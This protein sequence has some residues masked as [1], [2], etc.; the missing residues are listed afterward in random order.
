MGDWRGRCRLGGGGG[1]IVD[2]KDWRRGP[3]GEGGECR[4]LQCQ[5]TAPGPWRGLDGVA[6]TSHSA[7]A[8]VCRPPS[9]VCRLPVRCSPAV[10]HASRPEATALADVSRQKASPAHHA[11]ASAPAPATTPVLTAASV[12]SVDLAGAVPWPRRP[13]GTSALGP[14]PRTASCWTRPRRRGH[15]HHY[16]L[17]AIRTPSSSPYLISPSRQRL[18]CCSLSPFYSFLLLLPP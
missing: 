9:T 16:M 11:Q 8:G 12:D 6:S 18:S 3:G 2:G 7:P 17:P 14:T 15:Y 13:E 1:F 10:L 5:L 4:Q